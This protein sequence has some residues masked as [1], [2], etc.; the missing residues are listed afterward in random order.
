MLCLKALAR[1][2]YGFR[3]MVQEDGYF[4]HIALSLQNENPRTRLIALQTLTIAANEPSEGMQVGEG[5]MF[6]CWTE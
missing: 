4:N 3:K 6:S 5:A 1:H 2:D